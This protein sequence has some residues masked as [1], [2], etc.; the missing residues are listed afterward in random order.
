MAAKLKLT[1][2][3]EGFALGIVAF[4]GASFVLHCGF[5]MGPWACQADKKPDPLPPPP[6]PPG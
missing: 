4:I 6:E 2:R 5:G 3:Q 1:K